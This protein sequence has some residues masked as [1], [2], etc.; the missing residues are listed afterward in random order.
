MMGTCEEQ[1]CS[2]LMTFAVTLPVPY[3]A[4]STQLGNDFTADV[5]P[6]LHRVASSVRP[7]WR[8]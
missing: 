2:Q 6:C 1:I 5:R 3:E 7:A 4:I 8:K